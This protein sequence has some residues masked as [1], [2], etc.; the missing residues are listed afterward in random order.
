MHS[1]LYK[2]MYYTRNTIPKCKYH[3]DKCVIVY[4]IEIYFNSFLELFLGFLDPL[5]LDLGDQFAH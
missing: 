5:D 3:M 1:R 2:I 4:K